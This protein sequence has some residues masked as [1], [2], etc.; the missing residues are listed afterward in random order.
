[1]GVTP[2]EGVVGVGVG[3]GVVGVGVG[4]VAD[5]G[6]GVGDGCVAAVGVGVGVEVTGVGV[7][8]FIGCVGVGVLPLANVVG[9]GVVWARPPGVTPA[10]ATRTKQHESSRPATIMKIT[11]RLR[12]P[13]CPPKTLAIFLQNCLIMTTSK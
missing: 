13:P 7:G 10:T 6:V 1:V 3:G 2:L 5:V 12:I 11:A 9:V 4:C 8:V